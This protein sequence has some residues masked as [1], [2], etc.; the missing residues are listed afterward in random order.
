MAL[1]ACVLFDPPGESRHR[2]LGDCLESLYRT[3]DWSRHRLILSDNGTTTQSEDE[4][5]GRM[6][7]Y[8]WPNCTVI[9]N[10][11]NI[12]TA[13]AANKAW[14]LRQ[15]GEHCLKLDSDAVLHESGWLDKLEECIERDPR[16]GIIGLKRKDLDESPFARPGTWQHSQLKM[17]PHRKGE[18]WLI[19]ERVNHVM[20]TCQLYNSALLDKIGYLVQMGTYGFDD[21]L[22]AIRCDLAGFYSCF[23]PHYVIDHPD[24]GKCQYTQW[25]RDEA[26]RRMARYHQ[27]VDEYKRGFRNIYSGPDEDLA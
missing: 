3:V 9:R 8:N 1:I 25:K 2:L 17:L 24:P 4:F 12:G 21:S 19:V 7:G 6:N 23:Y 10:G 15:P 13:R 22:A 18:P 26:G 16:I 27:V 11:S 14:Q 20:G 5:H